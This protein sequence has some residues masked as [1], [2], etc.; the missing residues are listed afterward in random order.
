MTRFFH[1]QLQ[2]I[3]PSYD[4]WGNFPRDLI[5]HDPSRGTFF[6]DDFVKVPTHASATAIDGWYAYADTGVTIKPLGG[7]TKGTAFGVLQI[8]GADADNDEGWMQLGDN[9]ANPFNFDTS[10]PLW[11]EA[12]IR[13]PVVTDF[14]LFVGLAEEGL[15]AANTLIDD[16]GEIASKDMVGFRVLTA[17]PTQLDAVYR[18]AGGSVVVHDS[19]VQTIAAATWYKVGMYSDGVRIWYWVDGVKTETTGALLSASGFPD[20]EKLSPIFGIKTGAVVEKKFDIDWIQVGQ[21]WP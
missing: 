1:T 19:A 15:A 7:Q 2:G 20:S 12:R 8:A 13:L 6:R 5:E 10:Y 18:T 16:T 21:V 17:T 4:L 3:G 11:F 14:G 9:L